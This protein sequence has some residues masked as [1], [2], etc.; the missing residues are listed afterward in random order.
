[1]PERKPFCLV[2]TPKEYT[3]EAFTLGCDDAWYYLVR[4]Y[5]EAAPYEELI[6]QYLKAEVALW[7]ESLR[8]NTS[9]YREESPVEIFNG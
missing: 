2:N 6:R 9:Q 7:D 3:V 4:E 5:P 8:Q 1:M